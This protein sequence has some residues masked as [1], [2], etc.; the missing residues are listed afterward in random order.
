MTAVESHEGSINQRMYWMLDRRIGESGCVNVPILLDLDGERLDAARLEAALQRIVERHEILRTTLVREPGHPLEQRIHASGAFTLDEVASTPAS[1]DAEVGE[2]VRTR[3]DLSEMPLRCRLFRLAGNAPDVLAI[4]LPHTATDG[5][6][7]G[8]F[9]DE[10][11]VLLAGPAAEWCTDPRAAPCWQYRQF[12]EWQ[13]SRLSGSRLRALHEHSA[14][15]VEGVEALD[16]APPSVT[17]RSDHLYFTVPEE[18]V[19]TLDRLGHQQRATSFAVWVAVAGPAILA[20]SNRG[21]AIIST[22]MSN[23]KPR[24][25]RTSQGAYANLVPLRICGDAGALEERIERARSS[26][27][28]ALSI[29]ELPLLSTPPVDDDPRRT[30]TRFVLQQSVDFPS[31]TMFGATHA[32]K[33]SMPGGLGTRLNVELAIARTGRGAECYLRYPTDQYDAATMADLAS[34]IEGE[35]QA[36]T[37]RVGG[38]GTWSTSAPSPIAH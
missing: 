34:R 37:D 15:Y 5:W 26:V 8:V 4:N 10:L 12:T 24:A 30:A 35:V 17:S 38:D 32:T 33:R 9:I 16:P 28:T 11:R 13:T 19:R 25:S 23:R 2:F 27:S 36:V 3:I 29:Q 22:L 18:T 31:E 1:I 7:S 21:E 20:W 14:R 6:S